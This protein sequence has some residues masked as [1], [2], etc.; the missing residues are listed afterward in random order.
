MNEPTQTDA[1]DVVFPEEF[2]GQVAEVIARSDDP[3]QP[4]AIDK[5][6]ARQAPEFD[7]L[8]SWRKACEPMV[9]VD[10]A[11]KMVEPLDDLPVFLAPPDGE[12][13][14]YDVPEVLTRIAQALQALTNDLHV[15]AST[16]QAVETDQ[17]ALLME[18]RTRNEDLCKIVDAY[19]VDR[20]KGIE[21]QQAL[22]GELGAARNELQQTKAELLKTKIELSN[23]RE[24]IVIVD[25]QH[26]CA[27][28]RQRAGTRMILLGLVLWAAAI[29]IA[30]AAIV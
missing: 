21:M 1:A 29:V 5:A 4:D 10:V 30:V 12:T 23:L 28:A 7:A 16:S 9:A 6:E 25:E 3:L 13:G 15:T 19:E 8:E 27:E 14:H 18:A 2:A 20:R 11:R 17:A 22:H 26:G 24:L